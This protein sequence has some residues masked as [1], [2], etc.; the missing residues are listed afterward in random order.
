MQLGTG[1]IY[2]DGKPAGTLTDVE[3]SIKRVPVPCFEVEGIKEFPCGYCGN[4]PQGMSMEE[5][6]NLW[7]FLDG[8]FV[9]PEC[10]R[11]ITGGDL[12]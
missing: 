3:V 1:I 6:F 10:H 11:K 2:I 4:F 12:P 9:C 8:K 7:G 5:A